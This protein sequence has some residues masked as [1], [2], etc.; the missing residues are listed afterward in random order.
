MGWGGWWWRWGG[1][2]WIRL[3]AGELP[4]ARLLVR[5]PPARITRADARHNMALRRTESIVNRAAR[6]NLRLGSENSKVLGGALVVLQYSLY[7]E[8]LG[9]ISYFSSGAW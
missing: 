9:R 3:G 8:Y 6:V 2:S 5:I 4:V 7:D 1:L